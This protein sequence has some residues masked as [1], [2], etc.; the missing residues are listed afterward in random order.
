MAEDI[1]QLKARFTQLF[2]PTQKLHIVRAP[3][4]VN[5]IGEHTDYNDGFVFPMAIEP[6]IKVICRSRS[7][8]IVKIASTV[9]PNEFVEFSLQKKIER[10]KPSWGNYARGI[11][12]ELIKAGIP[13]SGMDALISNSLPVGGGLSSSAAILISLAKA[14]LKLAGLDIEPDRLALIAQKAEHEYAHVPSGIMDQ[15]IVVSA[16]AGHAMMLDCRDLHKQFIP[17]DA[18]EL[19]V[20]IANSMVRHELGDGQYAIRRKQCEE[21][22]AVL[23]RD[24]PNI[25]ALRDVKIDQVE[26][27]KSKMSEVVYRRARHVV[28]E[29]FRTIEMAQR[30]LLQRYD[31]AGELMIKSHNSLRDDYEVSCV[32]LDFLVEQAMKIKGVYGARMTGGGFGGSIVALVQPRSVEGLTE[33]LHKTYTQKFERQP[34]VFTTTATAGASVLE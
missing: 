27:A 5:L 17:I 25:K 26:S 15:T 31:E 29:N 22:V 18:K 30:L 24:L 14:F 3:G 13:L 12:A 2:G 7:D 28:T 8:E 9:Y 34:S 10:G 32:E 6:E 23:K 19:R 21:A 16:R 11:A 20:V 4:R 1:P 33:H